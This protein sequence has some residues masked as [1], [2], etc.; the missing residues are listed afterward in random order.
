MSESVADW[1]ATANTGAPRVGAYTRNI[2]RA[3]LLTPMRST[4]IN[5]VQQL[6]SVCIMCSLL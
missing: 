4:R 3:R 6:S 5:I 1:K 2:E